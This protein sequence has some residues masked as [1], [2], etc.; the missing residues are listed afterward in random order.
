[1]LI[2]IP[3]GHDR[4]VVQRLPIITFILIGLNTLFFLLTLV[5]GMRQET[6][7]ETALKSMMDYAQEHTY[8]TLSSEAEDRLSRLPFSEESI[9]E[10]RQHLHQRRANYNSASRYY[11]RV[12]DEQPE[13][14]RLSAEFVKAYD[15][16]WL[17]KYGFIPRHHKTSLFNY[18]SCMFLHGGWMHLIGN[19]LFLFLSGIAIEEVWGRGVFT[20]FYLLSGLGA[21]AAHFAFNPQSTIPTI[22]ASGAIAGL[23]G[24]FMVRHFKAR[25]RL[26]YVYWFFFRFK[27]GTF[28]IPAYVVLPFWLL[29][30]LFY[31]TLY[32]SLGV[33]GGV[34]FWA[35]IGGFAC[36]AAIAAAIYHGRIEERFIAPQIEAKISFGTSRVVTES[37]AHLEK[38]EA[39][40]ALRKL[41]QHLQTKPDDTDAL[42]A[43]A[44]TYA[45]LNQREQEISTYL[46]LIRAQLKN[47]DREAALEAYGLL[48]DTYAEGEPQHPLPGREW[49]ILCEY[50]NEQ[51]L[52]AEAVGE[53]EKL[54]RAHS[55]EP[56]AAKA[57][58]CAAEICLGHLNDPARARDLFYRASTL[59]PNI[60][61]WRDRIAKGLAQIEAPQAASG[62]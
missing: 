27:A 38:G 2:I 62:V 56:F 59:A 19:M 17:F 60:P 18:L 49:M 35:H 20:A 39:N 47:N 14:D 53:Y 51:N 33:N 9:E 6:R 30:Q 25:V 5:V 61:A 57:L 23:M 43:M 45:Q 15:G 13:M 29:Q 12:L 41:L 46:R 36:G 16:F 55:T 31:A 40:I 32:Q 24:A 58:I 37:L 4:Q 22:G 7:L 50:L 26:A 8:V 34:A 3:I 48:L 28:E 44:R 52:R 1:M 54:A 11:S 10:V 42:L 21:T